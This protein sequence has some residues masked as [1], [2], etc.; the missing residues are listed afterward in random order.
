MESTATQLENFRR[1]AA[2]RHAQVIG[3]LRLVAG[4]A[5]ILTARHCNALYA[6]GPSI[7]LTP[8]KVTSTCYTCVA[9]VH[10]CAR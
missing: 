4:E 5:Y 10:C 1:E 8:L 3:E 6:P 2:D 9:C 7:R